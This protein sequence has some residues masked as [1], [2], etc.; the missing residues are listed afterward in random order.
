MELS[1]P[2]KHYH[3]SSG[4][5]FA[6]WICHSHLLLDSC[7]GAGEKLWTVFLFNEIW[8]DVSA[9][10]RLPVSRR[11]NMSWTGGREILGSTELNVFLSPSLL[12]LL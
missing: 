2:T 6:R 10:Y 9:G 7:S 5:Q 12:L 1:F 8:P 11:M 3:F 4:H